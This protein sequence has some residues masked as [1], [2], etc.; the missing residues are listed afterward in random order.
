MATKLDKFTRELSFVVSAAGAVGAFIT[1]I[2]AGDD[3]GN[4]RWR[5]LIIGVA[6]TAVPVFLARVERWRADSDLAKKTA[7]STEVVR[8]HEQF[9][10]GVSQGLRHI[11]TISALRLTPA[12][13]G[14]DVVTGRLDQ[15][16][17]FA[18]SDVH[19]G[20]HVA[21]YRWDQATGD[22]LLEAERPL[23]AAAKKSNGDFGY[24]AFRQVATTGGVFR[25]ADTRSPI[26][27][28]MPTA[29]DGPFVMC[30]VKADSRVLGVLAV[31][32]PRATW[33][34][35]GPQDFTPLQIRQFLLY[36]DALAA[37]LTN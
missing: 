25:R 30:Q 24:S 9:I 16:I 19:V 20:S 37:G 22:F 17:V 21:F 8:S 7:A 31:D 23:G 36:A 18:A 14:V 29:P 10:A 6:C 35:S 27:D 2:M 26:R 32:A 5:D 4:A 34:A 33:S 1:S 28:P 11:S 3:K 13:N 12:P 15:S